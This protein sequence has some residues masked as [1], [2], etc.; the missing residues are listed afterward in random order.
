V[1]EEFVPASEATDLTFDSL[2]DYNTY[3]DVRGVHG[4]FNTCLTDNR[5][6]FDLNSNERLVVKGEFY[7]EN[8]DVI[9]PK[10]I[11]CSIVECAINVDNKF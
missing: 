3:L 2:D 10:E 7:T 4:F 8:G 6:I 5:G 9:D 11:N 1:G